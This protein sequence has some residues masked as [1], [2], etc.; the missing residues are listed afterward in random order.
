MFINLM[1]SVFTGCVKLHYNE[2]SIFI[3]HKGR[4]LK[5]RFIDRRGGKAEVKWCILKVRVRGY[6]L[7]THLSRR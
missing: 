3:G 5:L 7:V 6:I 2:Y 1:L 4:C